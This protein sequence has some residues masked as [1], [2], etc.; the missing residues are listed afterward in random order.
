MV[1]IGPSYLLYTLRVAVM[2][3]AQNG[4]KS[5][6]KPEERISKRHSLPPRVRRRYIANYRD[7]SR[8][9]LECVFSRR[10]SEG[11]GCVWAIAYG[12]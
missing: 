1:Y 12:D 9:A 2:P 6:S 8:R 10:V 11:L 3:N 4:K 7:G 5:D